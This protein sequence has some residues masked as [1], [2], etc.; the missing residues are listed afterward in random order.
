MKTQHGIFFSHVLLGLCDWQSVAPYRCYCKVA[1][2]TPGEGLVFISPTTYC[3]IIDDLDDLIYNNDNFI[4]I[5][6]KGIYSFILNQ[7]EVTLRISN[8]LNVYNE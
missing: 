2:S 6:N 8:C 4:N 3:L 7:Q 1:V 5:I